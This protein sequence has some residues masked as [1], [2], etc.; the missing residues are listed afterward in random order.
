MIGET[1]FGKGT[2]QQ[3]IQM[4]TMAKLTS[5]DPFVISNGSELAFFS[6]KL[7]TDNF[8]DLYVVLEKDI[9]LN[10]GIFKYEDNI[11]KYE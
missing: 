9:I 3:A 7:E 1:S 5:S 6:S 11:I 2:V 10:R 8:K 4:E